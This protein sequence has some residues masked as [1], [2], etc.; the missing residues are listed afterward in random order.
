MERAGRLIGKLKSCVEPED[1]A[2][3]AWPAAVGK[4]IARHTRAAALVRNRL[5]V[6]VEDA[7]WQRQLFA[8]ERQIVF[9][10]AEIVG[11]GLVEQIHF[12]VATP[13]RMPQREQGAPRS[14]DEADSILDPAFRRMYKASRKR[15]FA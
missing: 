11:G 13:R 9:R 7:V 6:E 1:L 3:G 5:V 12:R 4:T 2:R 8:L 10:I 15:A 14:A